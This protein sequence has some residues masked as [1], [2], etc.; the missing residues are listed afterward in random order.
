MRFDLRKNLLLL[1]ATIFL[2][3]CGAKSPASETPVAKTAE[4]TTT[5]PG[6]IQ[7][8]AIGNQPPVIR[9]LSLPKTT[10]TLG[11]EVMLIC[12]ASDPDG[13]K[14]TFSW[15]ASGGTFST[16]E[17]PQ[18]LTNWEA[19]D[20]KGSFTLNVMVSD[21][22]GGM[23]EQS[24]RVTV[25]DNRAPI[26]SAVSANPA[27]LRRG[28]TASVSCAA[29][30]PD[31]DNL[32][33]KWEATGGEITGFGNAVT[34]KAPDADGIYTVRVIIDDGKGG[35]AQGSVDITVQNPADTITLAPVTSESGSVDA[36]GTLNTA[37]IVGDSAND[38]GVRAYFSFDLSQLQGL[39]IKE[40]IL[41]FTVKQTVG[42][43]WF[44]PP[45]LYIEPVAYGGRALAAGDFNMQAS[46]AEIAKLD[47]K[48]P[49]KIEVTYR[50][51]QVLFKGHF[52][53]RL[54]MASNNN[55][56]KQADYIEFSKAEITVTFVK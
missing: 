6:T 37:Y 55:L 35:V 46:G 9:N 7:P 4:P 47:S 3:G 19:P 39:E 52:Q 16:T 56:N 38:A 10:L 20:F 25:T 23:A 49:D 34:W 45:F 12:D 27:T 8:T 30:D 13:D 54:R 33:Y 31:K 50:L 14:L 40:A 42:N 48:A 15:S 28:E 29:T 36:N 26:I 51:Q 17:G 32:S 18:N 43:P 2:A 5:Q 11:E 53:I 1:L 44:T 24:V 41:T 21:G 22:R